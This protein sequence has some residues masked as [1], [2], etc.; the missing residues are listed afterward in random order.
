MDFPL[1]TPR[2]KET[3]MT[4]RNGSGSEVQP[5]PK[6]DGHGEETTFSYEQLKVKS[7]NPVSGIDYTRREVG[8]SNT[9]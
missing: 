9:F 3:P 4:E 7:S 5:E 6:R 1:D 8:T 2:D